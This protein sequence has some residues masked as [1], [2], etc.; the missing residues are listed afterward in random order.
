MGS[1][2]GFGI[3]AVT[4]G[5]FCG[6]GQSARS[7][8]AARIR[9]YLSFD[10][11]NWVAYAAGRPDFFCAE[12]AAAEG[13]VGAGAQI[14][15][16]YQSGRVQTPFNFDKTRGAV[17]L[18]YKPGFAEGKNKTY[19]LLWSGQS[20]THGGNSFWLWLWHGVLRFDV[21]DLAD[22]YC[23]TPVTDWQ[24]GKWV[25]IAALWDC[26]KGLSLWVNGE[27]KAES[28]TTWDPH[29]TD[30]LLIG[31]GYGQEGGE[32]AGGILDEFKV[33]DRPLTEAEIQADMA[34]TL[35]AEKVPQATAE[36]L[37]A[38]RE[39]SPKRENEPLETFFYVNFDEGFEASEAAGE[40]S[41]T[42]ANHP[43][44]VPGISGKAAKF[45][46]GQV[47]RYLEEGNLRKEC[48]A[49]S[50]WVQTPVDG[51]NAPG[52]LH[53]F[54]ED[55]PQGA[56]HNALWLWLYPEHGLRW[57]PRDPDD[58][59]TIV[60]TTANWKRDE[61]H[62]VIACWDCRRGTRIYV[63]GRMVSLG[64]GGD[65][66][67]SFIPVTWT[68]IEHPA[69]FI[70]ARSVE[71]HRAWLGAIDEFKIFS[72]PLTL[73][74]ARE[75][76]S[77]LCPSPV[78]VAVSTIDPYLW[79]GG[80]DTLK[81]AFENLTEK[82]LDF[83]VDYS[84]KDADGTDLANGRVGAVTVAENARQHASVDLVLPQKGTYEI[85][86]TLTGAGGTQTVTEKVYALE[87]TEP[88]V[89]CERRLTL[90]DEVD[91]VALATVIES[92]PSK[93]V[94]SPLGKY[95]EA[96]SS[97]NDRFALMFKVEDPNVPHV[98]V[99]TYPDDK[100]RTMEVM[101]Q[102]LGVP[103]DYQAQTG[104]FTGDEYPLSNRMLEQ[105]ITFW[106]QSEELSFI[107]MTVEKNHPAAVQNLKIYR[108]DGGFARLPVTPFKGSVPAR[109]IGLYHEDPVFAL[110]YGTLPGRP[111]M[112]FFPGFET[113]I[114]RML[115]YHQSFGMD[116]IHYPISWY[117]GPLF[118]SEAEP[119]TTFG[120][121]PHPAGFPKYLLRRLAARG[122]TFNAWLHLHQI[123]S[124]L[125]YTV[126]DDEQVM[127]GADTVINMRYDNRLFYRAWHG[128]DPVYNPLDPHVQEAVKRQFAEI[129]DRYGDEPAFTGVTLNTVRHSIFAFGSL[130]SGYNDVNL[131]TF[132]ADTGIKIP[133]DM[134]DRYR[135]A[136]S[137]QWLMDHAKEEWIAWRCRKLH[138][139]YKELAAMFRENRPDMTLGLVIF[140]AES[141]R[142][143]ADY[144]NP[145][146]SVLEI[147][148]EQGIDPTLYVNDPEI[149]IRYSMVP[150]DLRWRRSHGRELFGIEDVR[151]VDSAPEMVAPIA[152][153]PSA[154]VN[155]HD[156]YF[157]DPIARNNPLKGLPLNTRECGWRV[158]ALNGNTIHGLENHVFA[159]ENLDALT[160]TKGGFLVGTLG[161]EDE[162]G[163]FAQAFR[164]LPAVK[165]DDVPGLSDPVRVRQKVVDGS[166]YVYVL[167]RL[168][169]PVT[170][171]LRFS[172]AEPVDLVG[173]KQP[174][175]GG[176][177]LEL[178]P[179]DLWA[180]R[181]E[182][183]DSRITGGEATVP[184]ALVSGLTSRVDT[185]ARSLADVE[186][187][188]VEVSDLK[189]YLTM[190]RACLAEKQ[191]ARLFFLLQE[192]WMS[193]MGQLSGT[194]LRSF[195]DVP[196]SY[197]TEKVQV[198][199]TLT[200]VRVSSPPTIDGNFAE[201]DWQRAPVCFEMS[202]FLKHQGR[203]LAKPAEL[204]M[205]VRLLYDDKTLY[206]GVKCA[207]P[208]PAQIRVKPGM[209][210]GALW[211]D[212]DAV[213]IFL[214]SP[215]FGLAGHVQLAVNAGGS[216]TDLFSS[217]LG[218][219][220][221]WQAASEVT[222]S[223]WQ[224][225]VAI[226]FASLQEGLDSSSGWSFNIARTRRDNPKTALIGDAQDEWKCESRFATIKME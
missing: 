218:W 19:P 208:D 108:M 123:D 116:T 80:K 187:L 18:W 64:G 170:V 52:W 47:L 104:V 193:K 79:A 115:D 59:Y 41:P 144:L 58:S 57:D 168:P 91:P 111:D 215:G 75:E 34:G 145:E 226:P 133:V 72:R 223:G 86:L 4:F 67:K 178:R 68:P 5:I 43:T 165:F 195:L 192:S 222:S 56:G 141:G 20:S 204:P 194:R 143:S 78:P 216:Q 9:L 132:Q 74:E 25:H 191:Y 159:L 39:T 209:R 164:T 156:R 42:N 71:G 60:P 100:P 94:D 107:F 102:P 148:R 210:D 142:A 73:M 135:F 49:I 149:V 127:D 176:R 83:Q 85:T 220:A 105:K 129:V 40:K 66:D 152:L 161:I 157:E 137:Y 198:A 109:E 190:A 29:P 119:L 185:A 136:K 139:Y 153:T 62:H 7:E 186:E 77:R 11:E 202:D 81:F 189:R 118:G 173:G 8:E 150:A 172:G 155:M 171:S 33:Y 120:G 182:G 65:G 113:V 146:Y 205:E 166:N 130:E 110:C 15:T 131:K 217:K 125:P 122:M 55:G 124:L 10:K 169:Y 126:L 200:A 44:I 35:A 21:R 128:K 147:A 167:N 69:F 203:F 32:A 174:V 84:L 48:G 89:D 103:G 26:S 117:H 184:D 63:D 3:W 201:S 23:T 98:A 50:A 199:R 151:T 112:H 179:Y 22:K 114:D 180:F 92:A 177:K 181:Q 51:N 1:R 225:E 24:A 213:E 221:E 87:R 99:V 207:E 28:E 54:R 154:S 206:V 76:F 12:P 31:T 212:D 70:G 97:R 101:L 140:A 162:I 211:A 197:M 134:R 53:I 96:G 36:E 46:E 93:I 158:S 61:W 27:K 183:K 6:M 175:S 106:P 224:T 16:K 2:I 38:L 214:R 95:R 196:Q 30:P 88:S 160:I 188:G 14:L 121:R 13:R 90:V 45:A 163:R 82:L 138:D 37:A 17:T 219:N